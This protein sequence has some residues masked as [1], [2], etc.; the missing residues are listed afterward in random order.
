[1]ANQ[2]R[3]HGRLR[4]AARPPRGSGSAPTTSGS[5][6]RALR[7]PRSRPPWH[8]ARACTGTSSLL[9]DFVYTTQRGRGFGHKSGTRK[10]SEN[11]SLSRR[12]GG[13]Q[14]DGAVELPKGVWCVTGRG[15]DLEE[16]IDF[17]WSVTVGDVPAVW[18]DV[19]LIDG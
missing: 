18:V 10:V 6:P 1:M 13:R 17:L 19:E 11:S 16:A 7:A 15:V 5:R 12:Y 14:I 4:S 8:R 9:V 3:Q 2:S